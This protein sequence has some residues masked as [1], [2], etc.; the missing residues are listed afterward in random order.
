MGKAR[1]RRAAKLIPCIKGKPHNDYSTGVRRAAAEACFDRFADPVESSQYGF[2]RRL[3]G[4]SGVPRMT[5]SGWKDHY[6][7]DPA[8][9]PWD[10]NWGQHLR[11]FTD[12]EENNIVEFIT[13]NFIEPGLL[14]TNEDFRMLMFDCYH[15]KYPGGNWDE[16]DFFCSPGFIHDF[17]ERNDLTS[18]RGHFERR[19]RVTETEKL[20]WT[21]RMKTLLETVPWDRILNCDETNWTLWPHSILTWA[22]KG[23]KSVQIRIA[24]DPKANFTVTA[25]VT[26]SG[27][28]LPLHILAKGKT[29]GVQTSQLGDVGDSWVDHSESGWQTTETFMTYLLNLKEHMGAGPIALVLDCYAAHRNALVKEFAANL[30]IDL[31]FIPPGMTDEFQPLDRSVFSVL[32]SHAKLF[33]RERYRLDPLEKRNKIIA[34]QDLIA[35]WSKLEPNTV[36]DG[37]SIYYI[38][39]V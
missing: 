16:A 17:K 18:R 8:W 38:V 9:R 3:S 33:F 12:E 29:E 34:V 14:F 32:K 36:R 26:T 1:H 13:A 4:S 37:W 19:S 11:V 15:E 21:D 31:Y 10:T 39:D 30:G 20:N 23:Q 28:K 6:E 27:I 7:E 24:G 5:L 22:K 2:L 35:S 25:T